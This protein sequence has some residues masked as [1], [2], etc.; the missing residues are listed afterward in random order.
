MN[1]MNDLLCGGLMDA[2]GTKI[3]P[4]WGY[5]SVAP[6]GLYTDAM[7]WG[8]RNAA[9]LGLPECRPAGALCTRDGFRVTEMSPRRSLNGRVRLLNYQSIT[10]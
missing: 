3:S 4:R 5:Q 2:P 9:P 10:G 6:L 1:F 7:V 8:Y